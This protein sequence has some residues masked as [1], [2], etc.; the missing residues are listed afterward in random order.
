VDAAERLTGLSLQ[1]H[2]FPL[3]RGGVLQRVISG[4]EISFPGRIDE[5]IAESLPKAV[6]SLARQLSTIGLERAICTPLTA[7]GEVHGVLVV[8]GAGLSEAEVP[9]VTAFA[10]QAAIAIENAQLLETVTL[11]RQEL[12][13]LSSEL[14]NA[15]EVERKR[16]S[17]E[18]HDELGQVLTAIRINLSVIERGLLADATPLAKERVAEAMSLIDQTLVQ[19]RD[20]ALDL[21]P[22]LLDDLGLLPALRW[23]VKRY[24]RLAMQLDMEVE[25]EALGLEERLAPEMETALYRIVQEALTN[26]ARHAQATRVTIRLKRAVSGKAE[27]PERLFSACSAIPLMSGE[28]GAGGVVTA[29]IE[30]DGRGFD[31]EKL[32][33]RDP[34]GRGAGLLGMRERVAG[35]RLLIEIPLRNTTTTGVAITHK[36]GVLLAEDRTTMTN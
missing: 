20:L 15:Q 22:S 11:H 23:Y 12:Q 33:A 14:V 18:L 24:A 31:T 35:T 21:R 27:R 5:V 29:V 19:T 8:G 28:G 1:G 36:I 10:N 4:Q 26:V 6:R 34:S 3:V 16:I 2:R 30:D 25:F 13:R 32:A 7:G 9:A 17:Q